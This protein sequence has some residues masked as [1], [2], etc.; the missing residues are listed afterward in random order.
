MN[1]SPLPPLMTAAEAFDVED[2]LV[3]PARPL[4]REE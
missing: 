3:H 4:P 1:E 2:L